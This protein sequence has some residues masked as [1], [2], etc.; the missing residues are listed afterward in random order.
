MLISIGKNIC[1]N[2]KHVLSIVRTPD[3]KTAVILVGM[4]KLESEYDYDTTIKM[5]KDNLIEEV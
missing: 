1:V 5:F 2:P 4:V 3:A